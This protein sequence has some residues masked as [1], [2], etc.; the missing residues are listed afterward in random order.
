M[1]DRTISNFTWL[2]STWISGE[3]C[4]VI[5]HEDGV[6]LWWISDTLKPSPRSATLDLVWK[7]VPGVLSVE[8]SRDDYFVELVCSEEDKLAL[9]FRSEEEQAQGGSVLVFGIGRQQDLN[10]LMSVSIAESDMLYCASITGDHVFM[11]ISY[12]LTIHS[13]TRTK[14]VYKLDM[15]ELTY[16]SEPASILGNDSTVIVI[17][18]ANTLHRINWSQNKSK[19][20]DPWLHEL[21]IIEEMIPGYSEKPKDGLIKTFQLYQPISQLSFYPSPQCAEYVLMTSHLEDIETTYLLY[22]LN[23]NNLICTSSYQEPIC[24][25]SSSPFPSGITS[26]HVFFIVPEIKID[27][28]LDK[29]LV[30]RSAEVA[31]S[32]SQ[33][34]G[35]PTDRISHSSLAHALTYQQIESVS[36]CLN[37]VLSDH[38]GIEG[39]L[40]TC[41][42]LVA[43][44]K[45]DSNFSRQVA[46]LGANFI[47]QAIGIDQ[48]DTTLPKF[49]SKLRTVLFKDVA[50]DSY[51]SLDTTDSGISE[52]DESVLLIEWV[53]MTEKEVVESAVLNGNVAL[54]EYHLIT[55][56][57]TSDTFFEDTVNELLIDL[58]KKKDLVRARQVM[59]NM[60]MA[61]NT[62]LKE[63][64]VK[65]DD[66]ALCTYLV[67][68]LPPNLLSKDE[69]EGERF[70]RQMHQYSQAGKVVLPLTGSITKISLQLNWVI[71]WEKAKQDLIL[72]EQQYLYGSVS[73]NKEFSKTIQLQYLI[74]R[75]KQ[76]IE[77]CD[78]ELLRDCYMSDRYFFTPSINQSIIQNRMISEGQVE[79]SLKE[80]IGAYLADPADKGVI[81]HPK[82]EI[83]LLKQSLD[84]KL[85]SF[86]MIHLLLDKFRN[87]AIDDPAFSLIKSYIELIS[88]TTQN[89]FYRSLLLSM[90]RVVHDTTKMSSTHP[91]SVLA[92]LLYSPYKVHDCLDN[93][94]LSWCDPEQLK[95]SL[96][97]YPRLKTVM[98][99]DSAEDCPIPDVLQVLEAFDSWTSFGMDY[100]K[101][102]S[103][104]DSEL[105]A[106]F[107][108]P[109]TADYS[110]YISMG[111]PFFGFMSI[112]N[113]DSVTKDEIAKEI[114]NAALEHASDHSFVASSVIVTELLSKDCTNIVVDVQ[115]MK[116]INRYVSKKEDRETYRQWLSENKVDKLLPILSEA[117]RS[118][119][120]LPRFEGQM[121]LHLFCKRSSQDIVCQYDNWLDLVWN[122]HAWQVEKVQAMEIIAK[123]APS[124]R[125]HMKQIFYRMEEKTYG[126]LPRQKYQDCCGFFG[127]L[128][129]CIGQENIA[130][131]LMTLSKIMPVTA[132]LSYSF[133]CSTRELAMVTWIQ[134]TL[135][136]EIV[137]KGLSEILPSMAGVNLPVLMKAFII[138]HPDSNLLPL[139]KLANSLR[140]TVVPERLPSSCLKSLEDWS[141]EILQNV[142]VVKDFIV[143]MFAYLTVSARTNFE[144]FFIVRYLSDYPLTKY[145]ILPDYFRLSLLR[146]VLQEARLTLRLHHE[147][148]EVIM[149]TKTEIH[150]TISTAVF[151]EE[152]VQVLDQMIANEQYD[153]A[154]KCAQIAGF[155]TA[156]AIFNQIKNQLNR[157]KTSNLWKSLQ[158]RLNFWSIIRNR[159]ELFHTELGD[160]GPIIR[161]KFYLLEG[162][163]TQLGDLE[164]SFLISQ[165]LSAIISCSPPAIGP[166]Q[167]D[168]LTRFY[169]VTVANAYLNKVPPATTF[170]NPL[171]TIQ[172]W[173]LVEVPKR[174]SGYQFPD[175]AFDIDDEVEA[176]VE[177]FVAEFLQAGSLQRSERL[178]QL[179]SV[180]SSDLEVVRACLDVAEEFVTMKTL[181]ES[182]LS[183]ITERYSIMSQTTVILASEQGNRQRIEEWSYKKRV[184]SVSARFDGQSS[185]SVYSDDE[186]QETDK[187]KRTSKDWAALDEIYIGDLLGSYVKSGNGLCEMFSTFYKLSKEQ[188]MVFRH[189][190]AAKKH[191]EL[192]VR[193][194]V[195]ANVIKQYVTFR[196]LSSNDVTIFIVKILKKWMVTPTFG[197]DLPFSEFKKLADLVT[198]FNMLANVIWDEILPKSIRENVLRLVLF[199]HY[200]YTRGHCTDGRLKILEFCKAK[201]PKFAQAGFCQ[202]L[203][204]LFF[205]AEQFSDMM[206]ICD[207][208]YN[209]NKF[210]LFVQHPHAGKKPHF[211]SALL[212]YLEQQ[213]PHDELNKE[214]LC[215]EFNKHLEIAKMYLR[216]AQMMVADK[217]PSI[218]R[219]EECVKKFTKAAR[220]F[221][222]DQAFEK[223]IECLKQARLVSLQIY[224]KKQL[225][226]L[227]IL[228]LTSDQVRNFLTRNINFH[229]SYVVAAAY[230]ITDL[231]P[232][233]F[234]MAVIEEN[235][236]YF[237]DFRALHFIDKNFFEAICVQAQKARR[238]DEIATRNLIVILSHCK[239]ISLRRSAAQK[240]SLPSSLI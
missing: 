86:V 78:F 135:K 84:H 127:K 172:D 200:C 175:Y 106:K 202:Q 195:P 137:S 63:I 105:T 81:R 53:K 190:H 147:D 180:H 32:L 186:W 143:A 235:M 100:S 39:V 43:T 204:D 19:I 199:A 193:H 30:Y 117:Q 129:A 165:G 3:L 148:P 37:K 94:S 71:G 56:G 182:V 80:F 216:R 232:F 133:K 240:L 154:R 213:H 10:F 111:R 151:E 41:Q 61:G 194:K 85:Y 107:G 198:D 95:C 54:G 197:K 153:L 219:L 69:L 109:T 65:T 142:S 27:K 169:W 158:S 57:S 97:P 152:T 223:Q 48:S 9:S 49:M 82:F 228:N 149:F 108:R 55:R 236:D 206:Y 120:G 217:N 76:F 188:G 104:T 124:L 134:A 83:E 155:N 38:N 191:L 66:V 164:R 72:Y 239:D 231:T 222:L 114:Y 74:W 79:C 144:Q 203:V 145:F 181:P 238:L 215:I 167:A 7:D 6:T 209:H 40:E 119:V 125:N 205:E 121:L 126:A 132:I 201:A 14:I 24:L 96:T 156:E 98:F 34:N 226:P 179:F 183:L 220:H 113:M 123:C 12:Q 42:E 60:M 122:L 91:L 146:E 11:F 45:D 210:S 150:R 23:S 174:D 99:P 212:A 68:E 75:D 196:N 25:L 33:L 140:K 93:V 77:E 59:S 170:F 157:F 102:L 177:E 173:E 50:E 13:I 161:A 115:V 233:V 35:K 185:M 214:S 26:E 110:F 103:F 20:Q 136:T 224:Y 234:R 58:L 21:A 51:K 90:E 168:R 17:D 208:V 138:F 221:K 87:S 141:D 139:I 227:N 178:A 67:S 29:V 229:E 171:Q 88:D 218:E 116:L 31:S 18:S 159:F 62:K 131:R 160:R 128:A 230:N 5:L 15:T 52:S 36:F 207:L 64:C 89:N 8:G 118:R 225:S 73:G 112:A 166:A 22:D 4:L 237:E 189:N 47:S 44:C 28:I 1:S 101:F 2:K 211:Q 92:L 163:N 192:L 130:Q 187:S 184:R 46:I 162:C 16:R 70:L 176:K